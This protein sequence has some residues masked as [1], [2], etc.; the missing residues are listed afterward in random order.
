MAQRRAFT[1]GVALEDSTEA[2]NLDELQD[3][4]QHTQSHKKK[5]REPVNEE[6]EEEDD[7]DDTENEEL[8]DGN[9]KGIYI[10]DDPNNKFTDPETGAHFE[11]FDF[12]KR[13]VKLQK[14]RK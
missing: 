13:L 2:Y 12:C 6:Q 9:F 5:G 14:L 8:V 10:N 1:E 3:D 7:N 4:D 11:Y